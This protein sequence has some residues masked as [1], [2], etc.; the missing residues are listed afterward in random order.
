M[1]RSPRKVKKTA[2]GFKEKLRDV[3]MAIHQ[4]LLHVGAYDDPDQR[5]LDLGHTSN[6]VAKSLVL[7][8]LR[9]YSMDENDL[10]E[11]VRLFDAGDNKE[12]VVQTGI[13]FTSLCAHHML[14]FHGHATIGY[15]PGP[16]LIGLSKLSRI[17]D[18][19]AA[20]LQVQERLGAQVASFIHGNCLAQYAVV[21]LHA[22]H[23]CMT[24]RGVK[25]PGTCTTTSSIRPTS[26]SRELLNEFYLLAGQASAKR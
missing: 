17:L 11:Q 15:L 23:Q 10:C 5:M 13:A 8:L 2:A 20:R 9:G 3:D 19:Y 21:L 12:L 14:P 22:E 4:V 6:R 16:K 26:V 1:A 24:C 18:F 7:E 25:K